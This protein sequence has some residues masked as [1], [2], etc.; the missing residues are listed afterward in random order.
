MFKKKRDLFIFIAVIVLVAIAIFTPSEDFITGSAT[1]NLDTIGN[2][3]TGNA[4]LLQISNLPVADSDINNPE[5][6]VVHYNF[7]SGDD[8][9]L[10]DSSE[11]GN[12][13][14]IEGRGTV[15]FVEG[16][17]G[18]ALQITSNNYINLPDS[19]TPTFDPEKKWSVSIWFSPS[20][21][22]TGSDWNWIFMKPMELFL[23]AREPYYQFALTLNSQRKLDSFIWDK[24]SYSVIS[25]ISG[26]PNQVLLNEWY[27]AVVTYD[28][29]VGEQILYLDGQLIGRKNIPKEKYKNHNSKF[30]LGFDPYPSPLSGKGIFNGRLD[31]FTIYNKA[32]SAEEVSELHINGNSLKDNGVRA[33]PKPPAP[34]EG[35]V[36]HYN[37]GEIQDTNLLDSTDDNHDA[38]IEGQGTPNLIEGKFGAALQITSNN[39]INLPV[40]VT[41]TFDS[42][43]KWSTSIWFNPSEFPSRGN[44]DGI[45]FKPFTSYTDPYY[46]FALR[47]QPTGMLEAIVWDKQSHQ[48]NGM[49]L[50]SSPVLTLNEWHHAVATFDLVR[51]KIK[52]YIDNIFIGEIDV[53]VSRYTNHESKLTMGY[54]LKVN[55]G[56][57]DGLLD[58][59]TVYDKLL[60][61][62]EVNELFLNGNEFQDDGS[63]L[64]HV[65]PEKVID[66]DF[67]NAADGT[68]PDE[69][70]N[71]NNGEYNGPIITD[72]V[73]NRGIQFDG[74]NFATTEHD[75]TLEMQQI[76][77][78]LWTKNLEEPENGHAILLKSSNNYWQD[79]FGMFYALDKV[80]FYVSTWSH[81]MV[82]SD[83]TP[84]LWNHIVGTY[85]GETI[86][87]YVN[88]VLGEEREYNNG[89]IQTN[90]E[91]EIGRGYG[92]GTNINGLVD[93]VKI[94]NKALSQDEITSLFEDI[95][96]TEEELAARERETKRINCNRMFSDIE[97]KSSLNVDVTTDF[98]TWFNECSEFVEESCQTPIMGALGTCKNDLT[99]SCMSDF[100]LDNLNSAPCFN[101]FFVETLCD[102]RQDNDHNEFTDCMDNKCIPTPICNVPCVTD[103]DCGDDK[104]CMLGMCRPSDFD[105]LGVCAVEHSKIL[106]DYA[107]GTEIG[108][109][110][111][112]FADYC[113]NWI[114]T[115]PECGT[116]AQNLLDSCEDD[117]TNPCY[118]NYLYANPQNAD[119]FS[120]LFGACENDNECSGGKTCSESLKLCVECE[121][122]IECENNFICNSNYVCE[123]PCYSSNECSEGKIC[124][125]DTQQCIAPMETEICTD[126][127]DNDN[128]GFV[129]CNDEACLNDPA[130]IR[131]VE[132]CTNGIDDDGDNLIDCMDTG[133][134]LNDP[135]CSNAPANVCAFPC[136]DSAEQ[137]S[138][139]MRNDLVCADRN[140]ICCQPQL[141]IGGCT[142]GTENCSCGVNSYCNENL[143]CQDN[144]CIQV[145]SCNS[146]IDCLHGEECVNNVCS[147][148]DHECDA[149]GD[150]GANEV[151][152]L[153]SFT[154]QP[155]PDDN[156]C[157]ADGDCGENEI[158][159]TDNICERLPGCSEDSHCGAGEISDNNLCIITTDCTTDEECSLPQLCNTIN[160]ICVTPECVTNEDCE[161]NQQCNDDHTCGIRLFQQNEECT[162]TDDGMF[163]EVKGETTGR[164]NSRADV[165]TYHDQCISDKILNEFF[166]DPDRNLQYVAW[167]RY[168]CKN[169]TDDDG[170]TKRCLEDENNLASCVSKNFCY[171]TDDCS[172]IG[173]ECIDNTCT[174]IEERIPCNADWDCRGA[175]EC[176]DNFCS[177]ATYCSSDAECVAPKTCNIERMKCVIA[178]TPCA[179]DN[180]CPEENEV[181]KDFLCEEN[182][183][184]GDGEDCKVNANC[185]AEVPLCKEGLCSTVECNDE[186]PCPDDKTCTNSQC[187]SSE[188]GGAGGG[189]GRRG[190][191]KS[192]E[193]LGGI[194]CSTE[195]GEGD[196]ESE[197]TDNWYNGFR[198]GGNC[199]LPMGEGESK[200]AVCKS[201]IFDPST[202]TIE[203]RYVTDCFDPDGDGFGVRKIWS[204]GDNRIPLGEEECTTI[205]KTDVSFFSLFSLVSSLLLILGFYIKKKK[206]TTFLNTK[207]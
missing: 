173:E 164:A 149:D 106:T 157:N 127:W 1:T 69:S 90:N 14:S 74:T 159:N 172:G 178:P 133:D 9:I 195:C 103:N 94:Y 158:C 166:C 64:P 145:R 53:D 104:V 51:G 28:L 109:R 96:F 67:E 46:Q 111:S 88:G 105:P 118:Q 129:D 122:N 97:V 201:K 31:E 141:Q 41:P 120:G 185:A 58:E 15:N 153:E 19:V 144:L 84:T 80:Y 85:D 204:G 205:H 3:I 184:R 128:N 65:D 203:E 11:N 83:I 25:Q 131:P 7:L 35:I 162:D 10:T 56:V 116:L 179:V 183:E 48:E 207:K 79:G 43:K 82:S 73:K 50:V 49:G 156:S 30:T 2:Q 101:E 93:E 37:F 24:T 22:T 112:L 154:C 44:W 4:P 187:V 200:N 165:L 186:T 12:D 191:Y 138:G 89:I 13:G 174:E 108:L 199:C 177:P 192:C 54:D 47:L 169:L 134:C 167:E 135:A 36:A 63:G 136:V 193:D 18:N 180:D 189:N 160:N 121:S 181:C 38:S 125:Y 87:I 132:S 163:Y 68:I 146:I 42:G 130:C 62:E 100:I 197:T 86:K 102:D 45:I 57:F 60:S 123:A 99:S 72:G 34:N 190:D 5:N 95:E 70:G 6:I 150:C 142:P 139:T 52:L 59:F 39:Y 20:V 161:A 182:A 55:H 77:V 143:V 61:E 152:N 91:M 17:F 196:I 23:R 107:G 114:S 75:E 171:K 119:C 117:T 29:E 33:P 76:S 81:H 113:T 151:C 126:G 176:I 110:F 16:K 27:H 137:C 124:N 98:N 71:E 170:N 32:L 198:E 175:N 8:E 188:G 115:K 92:E 26:S 202:G 66:Y 168:A 155:N 147:P 140:Q 21:M 148:V 40:S 206:I 78:S 194:Y